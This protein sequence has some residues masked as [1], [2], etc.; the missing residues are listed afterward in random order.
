MYNYYIEVRDLRVSLVNKLVRLHFLILIFY[1]LRS[2]VQTLYFFSFIIY[3]QVYEKYF[4]V[5]RIRNLWVLEFLNRFNR[6][7]LNVD[8]L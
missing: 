8:S 7:T 5:Q 3:R 1:L 4:K 6:L 2:H